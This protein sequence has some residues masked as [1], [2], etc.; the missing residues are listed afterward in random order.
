M[1]KINSGSG[2][3]TAFTATH[4]AG[5]TKKTTDSQNGFS[6]SLNL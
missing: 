2:L 1:A 6:E 4:L 5:K 3:P